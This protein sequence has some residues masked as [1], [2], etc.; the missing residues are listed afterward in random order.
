[1]TKTK[2]VQ[3]YKGGM[4]THFDVFE[5]PH[6]IYLEGK[7]KLKPE[8][9]LCEFGIS[10]FKPPDEIH[11]GYWIGGWCYNFED[12]L[13]HEYMHYVLC[14]LFPKDDDVSAKYDNIAR[15]VEEVSEP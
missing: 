3:V 10:H 13:N 12:V 14:K 11:L 9:K 6:T 2:C 7:V 8:I 1:M 5:L 15:K 4:T